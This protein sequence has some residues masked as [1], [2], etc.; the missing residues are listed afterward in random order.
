MA[1]SLK[2]IA[3]GPWSRLDPWVEATCLLRRQ[4]TQNENLPP[5]V[6]SDAQK[7]KLIWKP[8]FLELPMQKSHRGPL[9]KMQ[10]SRSHLLLFQVGSG[11]W[12]NAFWQ[13]PDN[14]A[15]D[16]LHIALFA[17]LQLSASQK[18]LHKLSSTSLKVLKDL[19]VCPQSVDFGIASTDRLIILNLTQ[20]NYK[21]FIPSWKKELNIW[22]LNAACR[23]LML[24][25]QKWNSDSIKVHM[26]LPLFYLTGRSALLKACRQAVMW[27][28][29]GC[30][31]PSTSWSSLDL[32]YTGTPDHS[33]MD[34]GMQ[35]SLETWGTC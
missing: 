23:L 25:L 10:F 17:K 20:W 8:Q 19:W 35:T 29:T 21:L 33:F 12:E 3:C 22:E 31:V 1:F 15:A 13:A 9:L 14:S 4:L 11:A 27:G 6:S 34:V 30:R 7:A 26:L 24:S 28:E 32:P 5:G 18:P 2:V 16:A